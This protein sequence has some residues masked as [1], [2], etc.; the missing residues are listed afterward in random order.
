VWA[1]SASDAGRWQP[2]SEHARATGAL[3]AHFASEFGAG[4]LALALGLFHD[5]GK[6]RVCWQQ[7]LLRVGGT[8]ASVGV[9]HK[10]LGARLLARSAGV[11]A[12][13]ILGHHGGLTEPR[14]LH[15]AVLGVESERD[16]A[17]VARF[18]AEVPEA[19]A[20]AASAEKSLLPV[21]WRDDPRV[22]E[23]GIRLAFSALVDADHLDTSGHFHDQLPVVPSPDVDMAALAARFEVARKA[24]LHGRKATVL[25]G[26]RACV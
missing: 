7:G 12:L 5:A 6:C 19:A 17:A 16:E 2:F 3:A 9:P 20:L 22:A 8:S 18:F 26:L 1:H 21:S 11:A 14:D 24:K 23:M 25:N 4:E 15:A 13:A 10:D